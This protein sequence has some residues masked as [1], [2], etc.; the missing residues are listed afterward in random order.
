[1]EKSL[2]LNCGQYNRQYGFIAEVVRSLAC[3]YCE[4][5]NYRLLFY[6]TF[7]RK[8]SHR[9]ESPYP[10]ARWL[11]ESQK[12][13]VGR[14]FSLSL[15][16]LPGPVPIFFFLLD[17]PPFRPVRQPPRLPIRPR[18]FI[19]EVVPSNEKKEGR[20]RAVGISL[21]DPLFAIVTQRDNRLRFALA[22]VNFFTR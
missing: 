16:F 20:N 10:V 11:Q 1:M 17:P 9:W 8:P 19:R 12:S 14:S 13:W 7:T 4:F 2:E 21:L 3:T 5:V 6:L 22:F 15:S 18:S